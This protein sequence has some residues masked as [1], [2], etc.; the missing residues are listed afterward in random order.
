[1]QLSDRNQP[2]AEPLL[3]IAAASHRYGERLALDGVGIDVFPGRVTML[4]GPNGAGK[5]TLFSLIARLLP[6]QTGAMHLCGEDLVRAGDS[7]LARMGIVFQQPT[8]DLDLTVAQNLSYYAALHGLERNLA[9]ARMG[10]ALGLLDLTGRA[11]DKV[12]D[13]NGGH[14]RRVEIARVLMT[15]PRLLLL[16][17]PTVGLDIPARR[18]LVAFL[19]RLAVQSD[20]AILWATH[21][22]DEVDGDDDLIILAKGRVRHSGRA[23]TLLAQS[24][25][26]SLSA[27]F[28]SAIAEG[29]SPR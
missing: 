6:L 2:G 27:L 14:R 16:D 9:R 24:G 28:Q 4:L 18:S 15:K 29:A 19:H 10:E 21:L 20:I 25:E 26:A 7:I 13:L 17:E 5:T 23:A 3:R 11:R 12:R 1:M 8:L 22:I